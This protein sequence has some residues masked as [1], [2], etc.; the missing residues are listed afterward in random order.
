MRCYSALKEPIGQDGDFGL[1]H[2][3]RA[4]EHYSTYKLVWES[5]NST[6]KICIIDHKAVIGC[7][8]ML[9]NEFCYSTPQGVYRANGGFDPLHGLRAWKH[10][11]TYKLV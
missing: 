7:V 10:Y 2:G 5:M 8:A 6:R 1:L 4:R 9:Y 11:S 3:L